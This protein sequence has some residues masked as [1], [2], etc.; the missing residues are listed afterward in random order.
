MTEH[1]ILFTDEMIRAILDGRKTQTRRI[2]KPQPPEVL[3]K[4]GAAWIDREAYLHFGE[5]SHLG[6]K[7]DLRCPYGVPGDRLWARERWT[8]T[9]DEG[10]V[11]VKIPKTR[12][13][14]YGLAYHADGHDLSFWRPSIHM[15]RWACRI[16]P[17]VTAM[18]AEPLQ[19]IMPQEAIEEGIAPA[20]SAFMHAGWKLYDDP[21][22]VT[23]DPVRSFRTLWDSINAERGYPFDSNPWVWV[24]SF[25]RFGRNAA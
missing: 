7:T 3:T 1:P 6:S 19:A 16:T 13:R 15:P 8:L 12:P 21:R 10:A 18:R 25:V 17:L 5:Y 9:N 11:R 14:I 23:T 24:I 20:S 22:H 2:M 4:L